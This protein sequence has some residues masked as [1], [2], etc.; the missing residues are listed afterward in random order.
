MIFWRR[1]LA[2]FSVYWVDWSRL[3]SS[4]K[5][6]RC[7][8]TRS[9]VSSHD[10]MATDPDLLTVPPCPVTWFPDVI[11]ASIPVTGTAIVRSIADRDH[12][13]A[14]PVVWPGTVIRS[15]ITWGSGV[16]AFTA[17]SPEQG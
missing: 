8:T 17:S 2:L 4:L 14:S 5:S 13:R 15:V 10:V 1:S 9:S 12:D 6:R 11:R 7:Y 16:I 3:G